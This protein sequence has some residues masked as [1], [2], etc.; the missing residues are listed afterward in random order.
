MLINVSLSLAVGKT[1]CIAR[2]LCEIETEG[3]LLVLVTRGLTQLTMRLIII[4]NPCNFVSSFEPKSRFT[5]R[6]IVIK[7]F[8]LIFVVFSVSFLHKRFYSWQ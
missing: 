6:K 7:D 2:F 5:S 3:S 8:R 4:P 1:R